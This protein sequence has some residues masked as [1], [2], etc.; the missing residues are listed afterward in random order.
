MKA[1]K[2]KAAKNAKT[3]KKANAWV[4]V[5]IVFVCILESCTSASKTCV[6]SSCPW[7]LK[8]WQASNTKKAASFFV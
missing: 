2:V 4:I 8:L 1:M 6:F 5:V 3:A 7:L